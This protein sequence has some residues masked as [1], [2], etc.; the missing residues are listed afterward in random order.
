MRELGIVAALVLALVACGGS[1][2]AY[3]VNIGDLCAL[4]EEC[5]EGAICGQLLFRAIGGIP[6]ACG[7]EIRT[8]TEGN[9]CLRPCPALLC[10]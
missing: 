6:I 7:C 3:S 2:P 1:P 5:V 9:C 10:R 4:G 8:V